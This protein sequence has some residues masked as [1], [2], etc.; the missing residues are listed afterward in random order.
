MPKLACFCTL[1]EVDGEQLINLCP[2]HK[3]LTEI[4]VEGA[5]KAWRANEAAVHPILHFAGHA[6][7]LVVRPIHEAGVCADA[8]YDKIREKT[9][10]VAERL[11]Q[12]PKGVDEERERCAKIADDVPSCGDRGC[13]CGVKVAEK[14]RRTRA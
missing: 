7:E 14:I 11:R 2:D 6:Y 13:R 12:A 10:A 1:D 3:K 4:T 8:C 9:K 5:F